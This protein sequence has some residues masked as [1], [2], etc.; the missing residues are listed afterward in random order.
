MR[1]FYPLISY[2]SRLLL[3]GTL[4]IP[5]RCASKFKM[6]ESS[7]V[8]EINWPSHAF[9]VAACLDNDV[10]NI[11]LDVDFRDAD[12]KSE[13]TPCD[14]YES[15]GPPW[16]CLPPEILT[17]VCKYKESNQ[18]KN[19]NYKCRHKFQISK[20]DLEKTK[21]LFFRRSNC[22]CIKSNFELNS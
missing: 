17:K 8:S 5:E 6:A 7:I 11:D 12:E 3:T 20:Q 22:A 14:A 2:K 9:S 15:E 21:I 10:D 13:V 4:I 1:I 19:R 16:D 18:R